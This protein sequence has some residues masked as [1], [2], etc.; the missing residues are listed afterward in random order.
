MSNDLT[1]TQEALVDDKKFLKDL[2]VNCASKEKEWAERTKARSEELLALQETIKI[3]NDDDALELFK[4]T[5]ASASLLQM[6]ERNDKVR[7]TALAILKDAK[8]MRATDRDLLLLALGSKAKDFSKVIKII[9]GMITN[10][11]KEQ[12]DDDAKKEYCEKALDEAASKLKTLKGQIDDLETSIAD[13]KEA[14]K[15]YTT[16]LETL[17]DSIK[18]LDKSVADASY[19]RKEDHEDFTGLMSGNAAA[20]E[21]I[22]FAKNRL[23]KFYNPSLY[24]PPATTAAPSPFFVQIN[25]HVHHKD[26]QPGPAP[27]DFGEQKKQESGGVIAMM[28][29]LVKDLDKEMTEAQFAEENA[30]KEYEELIADSAAK[31]EE[32]S[33]AVTDKEKAKAEAEASLQEDTELKRGT[34]GQFLAAGQ[35]KA[36]VHGE[37]DW[38]VSNFDLRK[39]ARADEIENLV[40]SKAAINGTAEA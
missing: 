2:A 3:L 39:S 31:R 15:T 9:D 35:Y 40:N 28:D 6:R 30:Q 5:L 32:D 18:A 14:V 11:K 26:T 36:Q 4:K 22:E 20:K 33:K 27:G 13:A 37:C 12:V 29:T 17:K 25:A 1:D 38:F 23:Q 24:K 19:N 16:D 21:L 34:T 10:L 8:H 7:A